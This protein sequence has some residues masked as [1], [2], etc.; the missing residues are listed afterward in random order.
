MWQAIA[1]LAGGLLGNRSRQKTADK[2]MA[3]QERMSNT[4]YQRGMTDMRKAGLNPMLAFSQG[5]ASTPSGASAQGIENPVLSATTSSV[6][7]NSAKQIKHQ[8]GLT[9]AQKEIE[10]SNTALGVKIN[11]MIMND[12]ELLASLASQ[13]ARGTKGL[14]GSVLGGTEI[15]NSANTGSFF[16]DFGKSIFPSKAET[17]ASQ[18][19]DYRRKNPRK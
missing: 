17:T 19:A 11:N 8:A 5:G 7:A 10:T 13:K 15:I 16:K 2:Q 1:G 3:F 9:K 18:K 12:K 4:A 6:Q 14:L